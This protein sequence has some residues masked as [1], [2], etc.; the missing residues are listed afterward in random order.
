[1]SKRDKHKQ[2]K[3]MAERLL[4]VAN[5]LTQAKTTPKRD[6]AKTQT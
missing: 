1:M 5:L 6:D 4:R 2:P 3:V